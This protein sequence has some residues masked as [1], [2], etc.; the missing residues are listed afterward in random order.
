MRILV[1]NDDGI[2]ARGINEL[3]QALA[4]IAEVYVAAPHVQRSGAGHGTCAHDKIYVEEVE[5]AGAK[6][7]VSLTG[8]PADC[9]KIG[10]DYFRQKGIE[11]DMAVT[12][13]NHGGNIGTDVHYSG[14]ISAAIEANFCGL[15]AVAVSV[16]SH[17][18]E[19]FDYACD[20]AVKTVQKVY[21]KIN[22]ETTISINVPNLPADQ[23]KG[24]AF[25]PLG[26]RVYDW[27]KY[28]GEEDG[29][30]V[31]RYIGEPKIDTGSGK[32]TDVI[33]ITDGY[34]TITALKH[35]FTDFELT[36]ELMEW[37]I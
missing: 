29:K 31:F 20:L 23:V 19:H 18:A 9:V 8:T 36:K 27:L 6:E 34:A 15:P 17:D 30:H 2:K 5:Y 26:R 3:V 10:I 33:R 1:A 28:C 16:N 14:T 11:F 21:K 12:G 37:G 32:E 24:I 7:A 4:T 13:I 35:D 25:A 22:E